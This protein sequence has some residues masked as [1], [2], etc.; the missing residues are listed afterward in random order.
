MITTIVGIVNGVSPCDPV[1]MD[2]IRWRGEVYCREMNRAAHVDDE[3]H[4]PVT[5]LVTEF[6]GN[7]LG[8]KHGKPYRFTGYWQGNNFCSFLAEPT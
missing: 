5:V 4:G 6:M 2:L 7:V 8:H 3:I 1:K